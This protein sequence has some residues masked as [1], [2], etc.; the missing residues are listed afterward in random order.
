MQLHY[1]GF[2]IDSKKKKKRNPIK[3]IVP[4]SVDTNIGIGPALKIKHFMKLN[5]FVL[6]NISKEFDWT[7]DHLKFQINEEQ[8]QFL[9][10]YSIIILAISSIA[11]RIGSYSFYKTRNSKHIIYSIYVVP[12]YNF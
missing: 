1:I 7:L 12:F 8:W 2:T 9:S 4:I 6:Q 11:F 10:I 3:P 5:I